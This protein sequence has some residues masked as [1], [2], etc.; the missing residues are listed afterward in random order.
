MSI[1]E[2]QQQQ[3]QSEEEKREEGKH[4]LGPKDPIYSDDVEYQ[5][6]PRGTTGFPPRHTAPLGNDDP[7]F[8]RVATQLPRD[9]SYA[10]QTQPVETPRALFA[11]YH[12]VCPT[13]GKLLEQAAGSKYPGR[14]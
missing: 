13:R 11:Q 10:Q 5:T 12:R 1:W 9:A 2:E 14:A 3:K 6:S 8:N 7:T 4:V